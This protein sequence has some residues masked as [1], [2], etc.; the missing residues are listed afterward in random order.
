VEINERPK[1]TASPINGGLEFIEMDVGTYRKTDHLR[2]KFE[3][4]GVVGLL[5][6]LIKFC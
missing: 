5:V 6:P 2:I 3:V 1:F 4:D